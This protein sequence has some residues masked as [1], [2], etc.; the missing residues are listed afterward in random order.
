MGTLVVVAILVGATI[1]LG[2]IESF[3]TYLGPPS[4][5]IKQNRPT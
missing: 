2:L 5:M 1:I 4:T 3:K